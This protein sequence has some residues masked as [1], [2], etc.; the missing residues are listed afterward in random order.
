MK[1]R[2]SYKYHNSDNNGMYSV[3]SFWEIYVKIIFIIKAILEILEHNLV[4]LYHII[5]L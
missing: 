2:F 3:I 5:I 4:E 1:I